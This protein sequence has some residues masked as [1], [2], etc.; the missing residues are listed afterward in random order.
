MA[1]ISS[2]SPVTPGE[3]CA[4]AQ[5]RGKRIMSG[6]NRDNK[7]GGVTTPETLLR[8]FLEASRIITTKIY[9]VG[10]LHFTLLRTF[11]P[12]PPRPA[13]FLLLL[14]VSLLVL[15]YKKCITWDPTGNLPAE[16]G[17]TPKYR[18]SVKRSLPTL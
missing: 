18:K 6:L 7:G 14:R 5:V 17:Q 15:R 1:A 16:E 12:A 13:D 4:R 9:R 8:A 3:L 10:K 11:E 2:S